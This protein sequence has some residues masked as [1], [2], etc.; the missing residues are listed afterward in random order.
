MSST[1]F[2]FKKKREYGPEGFLV[3]QGHQQIPSKMNRGH[4]QVTEIFPSS[5]F[6]ATSYSLEQ[7]KFLQHLVY[8]NTSLSWLRLKTTK[9]CRYLAKYA[10]KQNS[11][12][13]VH[14][15]Q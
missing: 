15:D 6:I 14:S 1:C 4:S 11:A 7:Q 5:P 12:N 3:S 2:F 8:W 13:V 9:A 10:A